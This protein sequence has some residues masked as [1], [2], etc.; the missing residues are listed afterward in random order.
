MWGFFTSFV[1]YLLTIENISKFRFETVFFIYSFVLQIV[2]WW[3]SIFA[4]KNV[5]HTIPAY[6]CL[7]ISWAGAEIQIWACFTQ[8]FNEVPS[9]QSIP[10]AL[11]FSSIAGALLGWHAQQ[12]CTEILTHRHP[13]SETLPVAFALSEMQPL[14][15]GTV[16]FLWM[17]SLQFCL[18]GDNCFN[19]KYDLNYSVYRTF[20]SC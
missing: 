4:Q 17:P 6:L 16:G 10:T 7:P 18:A 12:G 11:K 19:S 5:L 1:Q 9:R 14:A 13:I 15:L 2:T 3:G 20:C 8:N